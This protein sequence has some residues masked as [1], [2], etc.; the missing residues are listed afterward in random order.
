M[1]KHTL[2][3]GAYIL[4]LCSGVFV[5][6]VLIPRDYSK[7]GSL[8]PLIAFLQALVF[9]IYGGFPYLYLGN[10]WPVVSVPLFLRVI[11]SCLIFAGLGFLGYG[12][13]RLGIVRSLGMNSFRLEQSGLYRF[14]RNPQ[15]IA[16]GLYVI[17]FFILWP[18]WY[19]AGWVFLYFVFIH[20]MVLAEEE[21]LQKQYG[22]EYT[23]YCKE[24]PR[25]LGR[26]S[27]LRNTAG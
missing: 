6:R 5:L 11:G 1:S 25:Y 4:L 2:N 3:L 17:G 21:F 15:A 16:C 19:A 7:R 13:I 23:Q 26:S 10:D 9:F 24:V 20:I 22:L 18:S 12:V 8:S 14:S 27:I